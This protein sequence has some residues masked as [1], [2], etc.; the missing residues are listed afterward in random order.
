[1]NES[2]LALS[3]ASFCK[4]LHRLYYF[5]LVVLVN[6]LLKSLRY[7]FTIVFNSIK[8]FWRKHSSVILDLEQFRHLGIYFYVFSEVYFLRCLFISLKF[9]NFCLKAAPGIQFVFI[10]FRVC[11]NISDN[12]NFMLSCLFFFFQSYYLIV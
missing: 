2:G 11:S 1:M 6:S 8:I 10:V 4:S 12:S 5:S 3:F 9:L 7:H